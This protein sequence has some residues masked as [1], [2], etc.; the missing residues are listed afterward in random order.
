MFWV[1]LLWWSNINSLDTL[2]NSQAVLCY[3]L[4]HQLN[5]LSYYHNFITFASSVAK[6]VTDG[7]PVY[8][9]MWPLSSWALSATVTHRNIHHFFWPQSH[10]WMQLL[11]NASCICVSLRVCWGGGQ[12]WEQV[13]AYAG[14]STTWIVSCLLYLQHMLYEAGFARLTNMSVYAKSS[15]KRCISERYESF[16][17]CS[18]SE[19]WVGGWGGALFLVATQLI[20]VEHIS[21]RSSKVCPKMWIGNW[22]KV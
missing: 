7:P 2:L 13:S 5:Y 20:L 8:H 14:M 16:R 1:V 3:I 11:A 15:C 6:Q 12:R 4:V 17:V 10:C 22:E 18:G 19:R 21:G 9:A